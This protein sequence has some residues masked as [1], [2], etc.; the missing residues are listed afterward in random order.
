MFSLARADH[1][2][3]ASHSGDSSVN[4]FIDPVINPRADISAVQFRDIVLVPVPK[5]FA[6]I[7]PVA[8]SVMALVPAQYIDPIN[9]PVAVTTISQVPLAETTSDRSP[10]AVSVIQQVQSQFTPITGLAVLDT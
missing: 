10:R 7:V 2:A 3:L 6:H 4:G 5:A 1:T 8:D 9:S